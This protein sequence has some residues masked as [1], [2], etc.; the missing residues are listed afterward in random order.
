MYESEPLRQGEISDMYS[1]GYGGFG[2]FFFCFFCFLGPHLQQM[3]VP[4]FGVESGL[5]LLAFVIAMATQD[6]SLQPK[7][8]LTSLPD[9]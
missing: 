6:L 4:R 8:Q 5:Q 2:F 3:E 9:P 7:L 1:S